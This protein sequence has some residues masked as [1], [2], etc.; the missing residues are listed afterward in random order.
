[1]KKLNVT[2]IKSLNGLT[3]R[4]KQTVYGLGLGKKINTVRKIDDTAANRGMIAKVKF[5]L[6]VSEA[7]E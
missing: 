4:Q 3:Q 7:L 2:L 5:L 6:A 1:M